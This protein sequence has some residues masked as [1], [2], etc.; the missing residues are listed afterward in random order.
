MVSVYSGF[1][2]TSDFETTNNY[3]FWAY[4]VLQE[5]VPELPTGNQK[6]PLSQKATQLLGQCKAQYTTIQKS[7]GLS[8]SVLLTVITTRRTPMEIILQNYHELHL[9][10]NNPW[11]RKYAV[12]VEDRGDAELAI[13]AGG[14]NVGVFIGAGGGA[15]GFGRGNGNGGGRDDDERYNQYLKL[16]LLY[17]CLIL[18]LIW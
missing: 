2:T 18:I 10:C 3:F 4:T 16:I 12:Q 14:G 13:G 17:L 15:G 9:T 7:R 8:P 5:C 11:I 1:Q 6:G